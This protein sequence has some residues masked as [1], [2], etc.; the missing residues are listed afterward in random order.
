MK[1]GPDGRYEFHT[2]KPAPYP[3]RTTPA[4][5]HAH[6]YGPQYSERSI[7]DYWF[8]GDPF[9]TPKK[10]AP[11]IISLKRNGEGV[12]QAVR[13]I[14]LKPGQNQARFNPPHPRFGT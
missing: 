5:I 7:D 2:I 6:V 10:R 8:Q 13:D 12:L 14:T 11:A 4:H 3:H 9:I 1:T